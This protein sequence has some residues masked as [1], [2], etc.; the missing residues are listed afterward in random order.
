MSIDPQLR[1]LNIDIPACPQTLVKLSLLMNQDDTRVGEMAELIEADMALASAIVR[2]VNSA[3]FGLLH[4]VQTVH[5]AVRYL[6]MREVAGITFEMGLRAAFP[7]GPLL[8]RIWDRAGLRGLAMSRVAARLETD[9][10]LAHTSGLF[11]ESGRAVLYAYDRQRYTELEAAAAADEAAVIA[12]EV[13]AFGVSH[14]ALGAAL[15]RSWGLSA[16][17]AAFVRAR[18]QS[19]EDWARETPRVQRLLAIGAEVDAALEPRP[20]TADALQRGDAACALVGWSV[21]AVREVVASVCGPLSTGTG[22]GTGAGV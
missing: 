17:V 4:R 13:E 8:E 11:A 19:A 22:T 20:G 6:G 10:W 15:C 16:D 1:S 5:E 9:A 21:E 3:L 7:P 12:A 2:T 14:A 18:P